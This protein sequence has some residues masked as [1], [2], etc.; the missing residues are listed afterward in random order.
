METKFNVFEIL[1][2]AEKVEQKG[3]RFYLKAGESFSDP[4]RRDIYHK[5]ASRKAKHAKAWARLRKRFSEKTGEFGTF[6]PDNYVLSNPGVMAGLTWFDTK[7]GP[8]RR[9]TG[10]ETREEILRDAIRRE[11]EIIVFYQGL[12]DF[13]RDPA[14]KDT[15][16]RIINE[17]KR[18]ITLILQLME[19][20]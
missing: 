18:H 3:A 12:K 13:A 11:N 14:S 2:I 6:D 5:L 7:H 19:S 15:V 20:R 9:L 17:E 10:H 16:E 8:V 4:E 1:E